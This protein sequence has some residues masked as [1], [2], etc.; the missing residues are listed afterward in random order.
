M[1]LC[2][3]YLKSA[4]SVFLMYVQEPLDVASEFHP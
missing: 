4:G 1:R 3:L 2:V